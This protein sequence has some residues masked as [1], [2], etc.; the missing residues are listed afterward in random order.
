MKNEASKQETGTVMF[1]RAGRRSP[2]QQRLLLPHPR[3]DAVE[4]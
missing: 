1:N 4:D 3:T 2:G